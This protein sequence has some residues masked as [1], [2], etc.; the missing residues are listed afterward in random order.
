MTLKERIDKIQNK[1]F[2]GCGVWDNNK[3]DYVPVDSDRKYQA[4]TDILK[5]I[6]LDEEK[7]LKLFDEHTSIRWEKGDKF[8]AVLALDKDINCAKDLAKAIATGD[9][10]KERG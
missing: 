5:A 9:V 4:T 10:W 1:A 2:I 7:I 6:E 3:Q 8:T